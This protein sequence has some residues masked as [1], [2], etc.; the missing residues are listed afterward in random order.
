MV[1]QNHENCLCLAQEADYLTHFY[2]FVSSN[3][4]TI[5]IQ[6]ISNQYL[7]VDQNLYH[8]FEV[9]ISF[10]YRKIL[11]LLISNYFKLFSLVELWSCW[12][13]HF[14]KVILS[15]YKTQFQILYFDYCLFLELL[16]PIFLW[17]L[18]NKSYSI[19]DFA[20]NLNHFL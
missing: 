9:C 2:W 15:G 20:W 1:N 12:V 10:S 5:D 11:E 8:Q 13:L 16:I 14:W 3:F 18:E 4:S 19:L 7:G 17:N 6:R